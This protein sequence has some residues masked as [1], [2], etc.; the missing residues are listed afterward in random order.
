MLLE[1]AMLRYC[2]I[3]APNVE[4]AVTQARASVRPAARWPGPMGRPGPVSVLGRPQ[5]RLR[6]GE[7]ERF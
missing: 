7:R 5:Q 6:D 1:A 3:M 2:G 4:G